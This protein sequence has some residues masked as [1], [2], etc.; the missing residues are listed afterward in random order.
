MN[1]HHSSVSF[2]PLCFSVILSFSHIKAEVFEVFLHEKQ[3][4]DIFCW[5]FVFLK[6]VSKDLT[7]A[8]IQH[9]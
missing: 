4:L 6:F 9:I 3:H 8:L 5:P 1:F 7:K 2:C